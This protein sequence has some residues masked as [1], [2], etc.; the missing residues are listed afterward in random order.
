MI[1][2]GAGHIGGD[3]LAKAAK[4]YFSGTAGRRVPRPK[5][6]DTIQKKAKANIDFKKTEQTHAVLGFHSMD[7]FHPDR[8]ASSLLNIMLGANMSSRLFHIVRDEMA[9]CYE[10]SSSVRRYADAGAFVV[11]AGVDDKKLVRALEAIFKILGSMKKTAVE[12]EELR[13]AKEY[14]RG[15]LLFALEDTMSFMLWLGEK[16]LCGEK[17]FRVRKILDAV[18]AV[19][20]EDIM[21]VAGAIFRDEKINLAVIGPVKN[22]KDVREALHIR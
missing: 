20:P 18:E 12:K 13:R 21:R 7:R 14:Y 5:K 1:I 17:E 22:E 4:K 8:Y 19:T 3:E 15:Q 2:V 16:V 6:A 10:I 9:L 11:S